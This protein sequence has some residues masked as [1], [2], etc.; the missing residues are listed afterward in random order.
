MSFLIRVLGTKLEPSAREASDLTASFAS[1]EVLAFKHGGQK[2]N[3]PE[4]TIE[5]KNEPFQDLSTLL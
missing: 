1:K 2:C 3:L 4:P 5:T